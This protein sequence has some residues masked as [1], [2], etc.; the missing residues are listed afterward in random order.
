MSQYVMHQLS[1]EKYFITFFCNKMN[2]HQQSSFSFSFLCTTR[3]PGLRYD[4][5][6]L[7]PNFV[8]GEGWKWKCVGIRWGMGWGIED[9]K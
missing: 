8:G 5:N 1:I 4:V 3:D 9:P 7:L 2:M 6:V